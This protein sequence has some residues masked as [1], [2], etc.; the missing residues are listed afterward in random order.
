MLCSLSRVTDVLMF[1]CFGNNWSSLGAHGKE[2]GTTC[3]RVKITQYV[4]CD[5]T[6]PTSLRLW[7]VYWSLR[8]LSYKKWCCVEW[9]PV[10]LHALVF[11]RIQFH[12]HFSSPFLSLISS[13]LFFLCLSHY[14]WIAE[15]KI[16]C[17]FFVCFHTHYTSSEFYVKRDECRLYLK[18]N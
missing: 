13:F 2:G 15:V 12:L 18:L 9:H 11:F 3:R 8:N 17:Y 7:L 6:S 14:C 16:Y 10:H 1:F 5:A 4:M